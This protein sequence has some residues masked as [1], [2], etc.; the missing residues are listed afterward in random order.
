MNLAAVLPGR[1]SGRPP[2]RAML[3]SVLLRAAVLS[4]DTLRWCGWG[5]RLSLHRRVAASDLQPFG[6][7]VLWL[8]M[9]GRAATVRS[10]PPEGFCSGLSG[11]SSESLW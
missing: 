10:S 2:K 1:A 8:L 11:G 6:L 3:A 5:C 7:V 9:E 4:P